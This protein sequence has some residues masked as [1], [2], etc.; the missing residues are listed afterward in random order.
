MEIVCAPTLCCKQKTYR[1]TNLRI[2][3]SSDQK[4]A[5]AFALNFAALVIGNGLA[6][7]G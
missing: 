6:K 4:L 3:N 5:N 2:E 7:D 1:P